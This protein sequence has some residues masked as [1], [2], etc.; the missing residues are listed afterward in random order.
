MKNF[1]QPG[2]VIDFTAPS[3]GVVSGTAYLIGSMLLVA[4]AS[5]AEGEI[6]AGRRLGV[7]ELP[8]LSSDNLTA[9]QKVNWNDTNG[10]FQA[11]TSDL[12]DAATVVEAADNTVSLVKVALT[13]V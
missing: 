11:A 10:E 13:P 4:V 8:K 2:D 12:D 9:G 3:G 6:V 7:F 5:A 1:I